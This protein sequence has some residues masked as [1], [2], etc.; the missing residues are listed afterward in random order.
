MDIQVYPLTWH[1]VEAWALE[2]ADLRAV[3]VP[4]MGAKIASL[5]DRRSESEWL[6]GPGERPFRPAPYGAP[7]H[8]FDLS[9]WDEMFPTIVA[10]AY[11]GTGAYQGAT[12]PDHGEVWTLPWRVV[13]AE[14][15]RITLSVEGPGLPYRLTRCVDCPAPATLHLRYT[16]ENLDAEPL[17]YLWAAHPQFTCLDNGQVIFPPEVTQVVNTIAEEWGWGPPETRLDWPAAVLPNGE[18]V[19]VDGVGAPA[20][21][22]GRKMFAL[23]EVAPTW[24]AVLRVD[25]GAWVRLEWDASE[26]P[27]LGLWVDEGALVHESTAAPEPMTG[28]YDSLELAYKKGQV[29]T[30]PG[31]ETHTWT[32]TARLGVDGNPI[33]N[34]R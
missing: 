25:T 14:H 13:E 9:G 7:Y 22:R 29:K 32:L 11:P 5:V 16:L 19:R 6:I 1:D 12:L 18:A 26:I 28:W 15:G 31:G 27:Y 34:N 10:C 8:E 3:I 17:P 30:V 33:P 21:K 24:A 2:S 20:L 23:P 4:A